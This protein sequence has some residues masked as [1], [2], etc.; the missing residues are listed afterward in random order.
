MNRKE[1]ME[2]AVDIVD[3]WSATPMKSNGYAVDGYKAPTLAE[4]TNAVKEIADF[5][6]DAS[7]VQV[8][9]KGAEGQDI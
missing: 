5:L 1:A 8:E 7:D 3:K 2:I 9:V 4:K 6:W